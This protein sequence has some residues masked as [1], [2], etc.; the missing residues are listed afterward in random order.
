[1]RRTIALLVAA[2]LVLW[3]VPAAQAR[4]GKERWRESGRVVR[5]LD[6]DTFDMRTKSGVVRVRVNGIQAP[7]SSWCGGKEAKEA[8][9]DI[10]PKGTRVRLASIKAS[11]GNAPGGVWRLKRTVHVKSG[12]QWVDI[13]PSLLER[14]LVFPFPFIGEKAHNNEYL[15]IGWRASQYEVGLYDPTFCGEAGDPQQRLRLE[16]LADG[17]DDDG[18]D[19]EFVMVFNGSDRDIDLSGW[20]VQ[21]TS[22]L[23][24]FFFPKGAKV[25]ADD[26]VVVFSAKG[27]RGRAPDGSRDSRFFYAG[28]G[29]RWNNDTADIAF[30]FDDTGKDK[31]GNLRAWLI[32]TPGA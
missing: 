24:A 25:R 32:L 14:G 26:Y 5:V 20:M 28:T 30:L 2:A 7:E 15:A 22:P 23:N 10:L 11:S 9:K 8:L 6:G 19:G 13:A 31:T 27:R 3:A 29:A 17:P 1:M 16:V 12:G 18:A 21:D 4:S